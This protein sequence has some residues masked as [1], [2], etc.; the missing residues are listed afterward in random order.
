LAGEFSV[1]KFVLLCTTAMLPSAIYAQ[2]TG[3]IETENREIIITGSKARSVG[4]VQTPDTPKAKVV[5][6]QEMISRQNP[7]QS[8]LDTINLVPG[9]SFQNNDA[10]GSSGGTLTIRGFDSSRVSLTFDGIPLNDSGNYAIFSNQQLDPELIDQ[11]NVNLGT[12]DVDSPTASAVGGTVNYRTIVP[13]V[14]PGVRFVGS[15]GD[16]D[17]W[18]AFG[19]INT[20]EIG[21][22][23]T[24]MFFSA[25][26][27]K[28]DVPYN[29]YGKLS[30]KQFNGRVYQTIGNNGDFV[31]V[32]GNYNENRNN[33]FGSLPLRT[34]TT[35]SATDS[36][37][38]NV[39][40]NSQNRYP[41]S[42]GERFY[43]INFPCTTAT[44]R[45][46]L[47][48]TVAGPAF[49]VAACGTEFDRRYNPSNTG[50]V[51]GASRFT[52]GDGLVLTVDP[53]YQYVKAN[54]G[55]TVN[56]EEGNVRDVNPGDPPGTAEGATA[57]TA[58]CLLGNT[59]T[60]TCIGGFLGGNA[61]AGRDL[62][63]DGDILDQV[64]VLAPSQTHTDRYGV[65]A[66]LRWDFGR[67]QMI[68]GGYTLDDAHHVQTGEV[69]F[70]RPNGE[71]K[72][73]FPINDPIIDGHGFA[74]EKRDR[75]SYAVLHMAWGEYR[76]NFG[77]LTVNVGLRAPYFIRNLN[78]HC[79]TSSAS[80]FVECTGRD[81]A[82]DAILAQLNPQVVDP[83][84]GRV[85]SGW[86]PPQKRRF[87][88][89]KL[90]P[91]LG[92]IYDITPQLS[93]F[94]NYSKGLSVPSTD[95]L[96]N[97]FFFPITTDAAK[98][99]PEMTD[100]FDGGVR[101][102]TGKIQAQFSGW[103]THFTN[104]QASAFD[105]ELNVS[106]FRNLGTVNKWGIDGSIAYEPL[107]HLTLY[108]FGS[109]NK[110]KIQD[111]IQ[112]GSLPAGVTCDTVSPTS[113]QGLQN[114][115]FTKGNR[116]SGSSKYSFGASAK[117][118]IGPVSLGINAK[119][120]G[121]RFVFDN[122]APVFR[123]DIGVTAPTT[124]RVVQE[125]IFSA[126]APAYWLV[127]LDARVK[128]DWISP[129][130]AW[131]KT[132]LQFNLY[133]AFDKFFVGGF[134]GGLAQSTSTRTCNATSTPSCT[135][136]TSVPTY[137]SPPF[138]QIGAPRTFMASLNIE[139]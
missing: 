10:Y 95:N 68:R 51:R 120:T 97:S 108:M 62:N 112:I 139:F 54:G 109:W 4:G 136:S 116:E 135:V 126:K 111:N 21:P 47:R 125:Q 72:D 17:M 19:L 8:I 94:G 98:P 18:R 60:R 123:G 11:V 100:N 114:C 41:T 36:R 59:P 57:T 77:A 29:G 105:P 133:N 45:A 87:T 106:V 81:P 138:V 132:Y 30:K 67:G 34:D 12:T 122:N 22:F 3:T 113:T 7:G 103:Y 26:R 82:R 53:S 121:P 129:A 88:Y 69:G 71:P 14:E 90:L 128:L 23:R 46:G 5:L 58:Q 83:T 15:L 130:A 55:G 56:A 25:S 35:Q 13:T 137:G 134:G 76:G 85:L 43:K 42:R 79:F 74:L 104:R 2:S 48:D 33:F 99:K 91:N 66:G 118:D 27:Q 20:G 127:N 64:T 107:R 93:A 44:P 73:V 117:G 61:Y 1:K 119:R 31:S 115:A 52:L 96:Y 80:G 92:L 89:K 84:T 102:R 86:S 38:R 131:K 28:Y 75:E 24:R 40:P 6:T 39:G 101:Y 110:S 70:L 63:G 16:W 124:G 37:A 50:N 49:D 65:I 32:A 9:V 78:N